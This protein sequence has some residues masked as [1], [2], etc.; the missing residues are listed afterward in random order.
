MA[1]ARV[2]DITELL[3]HILIELSARTRRTAPSIVHPVYQLYVLQSVNCTFR[4]TIKRSRRLQQNMEPLC[5]RQRT[6]PH[7][8]LPWLHWL[9]HSTGLYVHH[10]SPDYLTDDPSIFGVQLGRSDNGLSYL[11]QHCARSVKP[12]F[13]HVSASWRKVPVLSTADEKRL[14]VGMRVS[15]RP[16]TAHCYLA[17]WEWKEGATTTLGEVYDKYSELCAFEFKEHLDYLTTYS[18]KVQIVDATSKQSEEKASS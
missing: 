12:S 13:E 17:I 14:R 6:L 11:A 15:G 18:G 16:L 10:Y 9:A 8:T 3:E 7:E 1:A 2:F 5:P 4:N